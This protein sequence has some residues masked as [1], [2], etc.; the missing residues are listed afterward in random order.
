M[1]LKISCPF[2]LIFDFGSRAFPRTNYHKNDDI[3]ISMHPFI[4]N[5]STNT[6]YF[7][8]SL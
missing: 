2:L 4:K 3:P 8:L 6:S 7:H 1:F 5:A